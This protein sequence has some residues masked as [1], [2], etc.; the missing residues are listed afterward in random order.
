MHSIFIYDYTIRDFNTGLPTGEVH[1]VVCSC[2]L[3][4]PKVTSQTEAFEM[5]FAHL[6]SVS[7]PS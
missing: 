7:V 3:A 2:G 6:D 1:R 5:G 4:S